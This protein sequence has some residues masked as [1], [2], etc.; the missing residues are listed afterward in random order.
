MFSLRYL[1]FKRIFDIIFV[2]VLIPI[3]F[4]I[5]FLFVIL[6]F[7]KD[8]SNPFYIS[9]RVGKHGKEFNL[10]KLKTMRNRP[11]K[12]AS[13]T[14]DS[15]YIHPLGEWI[16]SYSI[17][18]LPQLLNIFKGDL[19]FIGPRPL[20]PEY[21]PLYT[22]DQHSR[23]KVTPGLTG[24]AQVKGRN[25]LSWEERLSLDT[26]Y[27]SNLNLFLDLRILLKTFFILIKREGI[28]SKNSLTK[29]P[30]KGTTEFK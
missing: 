20:L 3:C 5:V 24:L 23:H 18:E 2:F 10:Y 21:L 29:E 25:L 30:F 28:H 6:I 11:K 7:L 13:S 9:R 4:P 27:A 1:T 26:W 12:H 8:F 15:L 14:F 22:K 17:D 19:S 16:R